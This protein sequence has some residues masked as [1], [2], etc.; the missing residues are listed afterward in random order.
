[1]PPEDITEKVKC[2]SI[3]I[4]YYRLE[5]LDHAHMGVQTHLHI[6]INKSSWNNGGNNLIN[7]MPFFSTGFL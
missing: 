2:H 5:T 7:Q 1:M 6:C 4:G 3:I